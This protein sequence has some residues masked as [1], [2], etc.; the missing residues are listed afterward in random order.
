M[1][2]DCHRVAEGPFPGL[3]ASPLEPLGGDILWEGASENTWCLTAQLSP[4]PYP[5]GHVS[6]LP[7]KLAPRQHGG[8]EARG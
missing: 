1:G 7:A 4:N 2:H 6:N 3:C 8:L 5:E